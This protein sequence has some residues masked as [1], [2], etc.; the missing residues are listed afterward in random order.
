MG[1]T[2]IRRSCAGRLRHCWVEACSAVKPKRADRRAH[3]L[4]AEDANAGSISARTGGHKERNQVL[5]TRV[6]ER[7]IWRGAPFGQLS[8]ADG[9]RLLDC[10]REP[11]VKDT[12]TIPRLRVHV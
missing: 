4:I 8:R 3:R 10:F 5:L 2:S 7:G 1:R 9:A 6:G 12:G 11:A